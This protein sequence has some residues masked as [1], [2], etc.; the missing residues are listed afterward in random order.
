M[1]SNNGICRNDYRRT[2]SK[3]EQIMVLE[4]AALDFKCKT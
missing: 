3:T 1:S 2:K 4:L